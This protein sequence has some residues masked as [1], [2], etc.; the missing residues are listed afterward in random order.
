MPIYI[1]GALTLAAGAFLSWLAATR[2]LPPGTRAFVLWMGMAGLLT[3]LIH[4][5]R[6]GGIPSRAVVGLW[7]VIGPLC[8]LSYAARARRREAYPAERDRGFLRPLN[9]S[10]LFLSALGALLVVYTLDSVAGRCSAEAPVRVVEERRRLDGR[11]SVRFTY[12]V[13]GKEY[14]STDVESRSYDPSDAVKACYNP[15]NP[16]D[17]GLV[18][19]DRVCG[20]TILFR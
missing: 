4:Q 15:D 11:R 19:P 20:D 7:L 10:A 12:T 9:I 16:R 13:A 5:L 2:R 8:Y 14:V 17:V 18:R 6:G 3:M 1:L